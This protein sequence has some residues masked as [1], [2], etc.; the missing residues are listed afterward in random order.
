M[1]PR[2]K[3]FSDGCFFVTHCQCIDAKDDGQIAGDGQHSRGI[4]I[5]LVEQVETND[6]GYDY[7]NKQEYRY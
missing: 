7:G 2:D 6:T 3:L 5:E 1:W 4:V